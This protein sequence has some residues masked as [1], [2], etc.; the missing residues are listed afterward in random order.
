VSVN[1]SSGRSSEGEHGLIASKDDFF[2]QTRHQ[3]NQKGEG[4][5]IRE[6]SSGGRQYFFGLF[7]MTQI[8]FLHFIT[9]L[10]VVSF[11]HSLVQ[12]CYL[13]MITNKIMHENVAYIIVIQAFYTL[14]ANI[15]ALGIML[16]VVSLFRLISQSADVS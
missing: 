11:F 15:I 13:Q 1:Y 8:K 7:R 9:F 10:E 12:I 6:M 14:F 16:S 3:R 5:L 2:K 4:T